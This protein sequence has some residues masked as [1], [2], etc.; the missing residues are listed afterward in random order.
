MLS[1]IALLLS[2]RC[3]IQ[4]QNY[5]TLFGKYDLF[6]YQ[7][8][9]L[10]LSFIPDNTVQKQNYGL[11][12]NLFEYMRISEDLKVSN[13]KNFN[14]Y[15]NGYVWQHRISVDILHALHSQEMG[16]VS[17]HLKFFGNFYFCYLSRKEELP[18]KVAWH[19][20]GSDHFKFDPCFQATILINSI[21]LQR[22]KSLQSTQILFLSI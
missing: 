10:L 22:T 14:I 16:I 9:I 3:E 12:L 17:L 18:K 13:L 11:L 7:S 2:G 4:A 8:A 19:F 20:C 6:S 5:W 15:R 21:W 1:Y